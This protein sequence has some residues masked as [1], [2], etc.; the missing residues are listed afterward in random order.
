MTATCNPP[1]A[2]G[3]SALSSAPDRCTWSGNVW[4][5]NN[6]PLDPAYTATRTRAYNSSKAEVETRS[7]PNAGKY[8]VN[9]ALFD[10]ADVG[11]VFNTAGVP[12]SG[13]ATHGPADRTV[14]AIVPPNCNGRVVFDLYS[15]TQAA[16]IAYGLLVAAEASLS[17]PALSGQDALAD[18]SFPE[19]V[20]VNQSEYSAYVTVGNTI[21]TVSSSFNGVSRSAGIAPREVRRF[22][23]RPEANFWQTTAITG[24]NF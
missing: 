14:V 21:P 22:R 16:G 7:Y 6:D 9:T 15:I 11:A 12:S 3:S 20:V 5:S 1:H 23:F 17:P 18:A 10:A 4:S 8:G 24:P 2:V 13:V 19:F